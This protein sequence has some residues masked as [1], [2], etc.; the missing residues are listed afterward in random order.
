MGN[1]GLGKT[2]KTMLFLLTDLLQD[3][4]WDLQ[5]YFKWTTPNSLLTIL[6]VHILELLVGLLNQQITSVKK[7]F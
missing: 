1:V 2:L 7:E 6:G 3:T 4:K 5:R